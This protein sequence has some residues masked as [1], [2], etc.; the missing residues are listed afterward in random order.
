MGV[1]RYQSRRNSVKCHTSL[2]S[3]LPGTKFQDGV[4]RRT[5]TGRVYRSGR[6][7][8]WQANEEGPAQVPATPPFPAA[9]LSILSTKHLTSPP[10]PCPQPTARTTGSLA[11]LAWTHQWGPDQRP[12]SVLAF[13]VCRN[14]KSVTKS[15]SHYCLNCKIT[16]YLTNKE[17]TFHFPILYAKKNQ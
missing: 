3:F 8:V 10:P 12:V 5:E 16:H 2:S 1:T 9:C 15:L 7:R 14:Y 13:Q 4:Q 6:W 11:S 17:F